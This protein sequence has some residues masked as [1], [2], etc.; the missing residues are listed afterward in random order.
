MKIANSLKTSF[1]LHLMPLPG[2]VTLV[3]PH[4]PPSFCDSE[5]LPLWRPPVGLR[6]PVV[7]TSLAYPYFSFVLSQTS[8]RV[9]PILSLPG[10][11]GVT[12]SSPGLLPNAFLVA[13][14]DERCSQRLQLLFKKTSQPLEIWISPFSPLWHCVLWLP[15]QKAGPIFTYHLDTILGCN[16][17][18]VLSVEILTQSTKDWRK[19]RDWTPEGL[20]PQASWQDWLLFLE[21]VVWPTGGCFLWEWVP[22]FSV[23]MGHPSS[24]ALRDDYACELLHGL[25]LKSWWSSLCPWKLWFATHHCLWD[26]SGV[27]QMASCLWVMEVT[28]QLNS[29]SI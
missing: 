16:W 23:A 15:S 13:Q 11:A 19:L 4:P 18:W 12:M 10:K 17:N 29:K 9:G 5:I 1:K 24:S 14:S 20:L 22:A 8:W 28:F 6:G 21:V 26:V 3:K 2:E 27:L 25:I 7:L